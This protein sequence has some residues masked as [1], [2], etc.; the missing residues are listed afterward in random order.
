MIVS[1]AKQYGELKDKIVKDAKW[2][3]PEDVTLKVQPAH[4]AALLALGNQFYLKDN[5]YILMKSAT[6][7]CILALIIATKD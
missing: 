2:S 3:F 6:F 7:E 5:K 1:G 4:F